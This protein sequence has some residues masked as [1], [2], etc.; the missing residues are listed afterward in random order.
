[1]RFHGLR[2]PETM[3][4]V[5]VEA[6]LTHLA[7]ERNVA[8]STHRYALSA[9]LFL[10]C[11]VLGIEL[12]WMREI[13]R[14]KTPQRLPE[15]LTVIEVLRTLSVMHGA[16]DVGQTALRHGDDALLARM[17]AMET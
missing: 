8:A 16:C 2:H 14:P 5:E 9:M 11:E 7:C 17:E 10:Y 6:F 13:G 3:G 15:A 4:L 12:P 1:I